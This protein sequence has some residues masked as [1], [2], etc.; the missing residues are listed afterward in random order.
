MLSVMLLSHVDLTVRNNKT[1]AKLVV[2]SATAVTQPRNR[3]AV[4]EH[5]DSTC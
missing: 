5:S 4:D 1:N 2:T 3:W